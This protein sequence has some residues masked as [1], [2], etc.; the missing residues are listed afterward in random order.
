MS[1]E[2]F[3]P[4]QEK[5]LSVTSTISGTLSLL[6]STTIIRKVATST[7]RLKSP[8]ARIVFG[9]CTSDIF[10]S[11]ANA[12][13]TFLTPSGTSWMSVGN[14]ATCTIQGFFSL[15]GSVSTPFYN[16]SLCIFYLC[17]VK[18]SMRGTR[19][20]HEIEPYL[21][22]I[23]IVWSLFI[24]IYAASAGLINPGNGA[25]CHLGSYPTN[26]HLDEDIPCERGEN[27]QRIRWIFNGVPILLI[28]IGIFGVMIKLGLNVRRQEKIMESYSFRLQMERRQ[29]IVVAHARKS[30]RSGSSTANLARNKNSTKESVSSLFA[31]VSSTANSTGEVSSFTTFSGCT[32]TNSTTRTRSMISST[33]T[34]TAP[35]PPTTTTTTTT[36]TRKR[37]RRK[38]QATEIFTQAI[39]YFLAFLATF[40]PLF[41][42]PIAQAFYGKGGIPFGFYVTANILYPL[43]GVFN[44]LV[45]TRP[46]VS[47]LRRSNPQYSYPRAMFMIL[48]KDSISISTSY[49][50]RTSRHLSSIGQL[51]TASR[52]SRR[53]SSIFGSVRRFS[54]LDFFSRQQD[55]NN[56]NIVIP[57][58][59]SVPPWSGG[60][61]SIQ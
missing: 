17:V 7:D 56:G 51:S 6:A 32:T 61:S 60:N 40:A 15:M 59:E 8:Y 22:A 43:Q 39:L 45:F 33:S 58:Q 44:I 5:I 28:F 48:F 26:C 12:T 36:T 20:R 31:E 18:Y 21:H 34:T 16:L 9:L 10:V 42:I 29:E 47:K 55:N 50:R 2:I 37:K 30:L 13:S 52:S 24:A 57:P 4:T 35:P 23:P 3:T 53:R 19:F 11:I 25:I 1:T 41:A 14:E 49:H 54:A 27:I 46:L 38:S